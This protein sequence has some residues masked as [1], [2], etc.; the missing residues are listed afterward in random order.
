MVPGYL[1]LNSLIFPLDTLPATNKNSLFNMH[2]LVYNFL[3]DEETIH[4]I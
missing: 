4:N 1:V 3:N 2:Y